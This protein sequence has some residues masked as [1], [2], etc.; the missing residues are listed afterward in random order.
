MLV[1][2]SDST[3]HEA[4]WDRKHQRLSHDPGKTEALAAE[5]L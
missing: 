1:G 2:V 4:D 3:P 5:A